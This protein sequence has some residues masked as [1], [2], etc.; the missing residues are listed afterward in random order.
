MKIEEPKTPY[1]HYDA[2]NDAIL[3]DSS[4]RVNLDATMEPLVLGGG[5]TPLAASNDGMGVHCLNDQFQCFCIH[6]AI[7]GRSSSTVCRGCLIATTAG[8]IKCGIG[9]AY[10][11]GTKLRLDIVV[12]G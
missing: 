9:G 12:H 7:V 4:A 2:M 11:K 10:T 8:A 1:V 5:T 6:Y 3:G